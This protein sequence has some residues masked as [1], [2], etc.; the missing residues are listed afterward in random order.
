MVVD[1]DWRRLAVDGSLGEESNGWMR[2]EDE[3]FECE[4]MGEKE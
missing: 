2:E 3:G 1:T 4:W